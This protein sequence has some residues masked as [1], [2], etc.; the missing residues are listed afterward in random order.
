METALPIF[1]GDVLV[2]FVLSL[3]R[4]GWNFAESFRRI[5]GLNGLRTVDL[6]EA[7]VLCATIGGTFY[8]FLHGVEA[9]KHL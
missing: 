4:T 3:Y 2:L 6:P 7:L 8:F 9:C 5:T 1:W